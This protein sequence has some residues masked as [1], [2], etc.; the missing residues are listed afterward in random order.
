MG[1]QKWNFYSSFFLVFFKDCMCVKHYSL[2]TGNNRIEAGSRGMLLRGS[3][4]K[5]GDRL[6]SRLSAAL[7]KNS[8]KWFAISASSVI[9]TLFIVIRIWHLFTPFHR[10]DFIRGQ[11][12]L[13]SLWYFWKA[14]WKY[15][16][17]ACLILDVTLFWYA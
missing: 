11:V 17:F 8:L 10:R 4:L 14:L 16:C 12:F 9:N 3:E 15:L 2:G 6:L 13:V 7:L 1:Q 5:S